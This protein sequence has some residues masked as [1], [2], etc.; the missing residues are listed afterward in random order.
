MCQ[1]LGGRPRP[2]DNES[3]TQAGIQIVRQR[4]HGNISRGIYSFIP[5]G[6]VDKNWIVSQFN[7]S[8]G[9]NIPDNQTCIVRPLSGT[10][11]CAW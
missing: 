2:R 10:P 8:K 3:R 7:R 11:Y 9:T 1:I 4:V 6:T 5:H